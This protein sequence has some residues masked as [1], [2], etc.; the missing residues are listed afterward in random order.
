MAS[1][2][3]H[4]DPKAVHAVAA[5]GS[6]ACDVHRHTGNITDRAKQ[7]TCALCATMDDPSNERS[8]FAADTPR[9]R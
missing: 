6:P 2:V 7:V 1:L 8:T 4:D 9:L 5:D 3:P